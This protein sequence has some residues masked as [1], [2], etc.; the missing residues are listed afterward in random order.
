[1]IKKLSSMALVDHKPYKGVVLTEIGEKI[2]LE[3]L[4]HHRLLEL[5]LVDHL[6]YSWDEIHDEAEKLEH[7]ISEKFEATISEMM[8]H[9]TLDPHGDPIPSVDLE[10]PEMPDLTPVDRL[11]KGQEAI[12]KRVLTQD[13][14]IL[15][16][17]TR[18][19]LTIDTKITMAGKDNSGV[20]IKV[21]DNQYLLPHSIAKLIRV[22]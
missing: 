17:L 7:V 6:N 21:G 12:I 10:I 22:Q 14:D 19:E 3:V 18:L 20:R 13:R 11:Q 4:R 16:M 1:M 9:P 2:A 15:N 5:Y 8:G